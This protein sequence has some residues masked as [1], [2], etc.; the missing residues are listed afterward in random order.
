MSNPTY[1]PL[2]Y[3]TS[4]IEGSDRKSRGQYDRIFPD[5]KEWW[6]KRDESTSNS[7]ATNGIA[8]QTFSYDLY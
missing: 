7:S 8:A 2:N 3:M 6:E 4:I 1:K 5:R